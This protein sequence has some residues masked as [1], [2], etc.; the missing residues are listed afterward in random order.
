MLAWTSAGRRGRQRHALGSLA[1]TRTSFTPSN[2]RDPSRS[3]SG[4]FRFTDK[5]P[6]VAFATSANLLRG[7]RLVKTAAERTTRRRLVHAGPADAVSHQP[8][9]GGTPPRLS[10][11]EKALADS[12]PDHGGTDAGRDDAEECEMLREPVHACALQTGSG[13]VS[14]CGRSRDRRSSLRLEQGVVWFGVWSRAPTGRGRP[15]QPGLS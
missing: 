4:T 3:N 12:H 2:R 9:T 6:S 7:P 13:R 1:L 5:T 11:L 8:A 14:W 15:T 10:R